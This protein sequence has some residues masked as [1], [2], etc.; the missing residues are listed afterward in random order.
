MGGMDTSLTWLGRL[1]GAPQDCDW[2]R[3]SE[4]Y[5]PLI[6][7]WAAR[8]GVCSSDCDDLVQEVLIV[9]ARKVREF[10]HQHSGAFRGW[11]RVIL[12]NQLKKYFRQ[13]RHA[14]CRISLDDFG[15]LSCEDS[16]LYDREHD[17]FVAAQAMTLIRHEFEPQTWAAFQLLVVE[18]QSPIDVAHQLNMSR[19]AVVKA[20]CRV[21]KRLREAL[22]CLE[23]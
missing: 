22:S 20:R 11:L 23:D 7:G 8:A 14:H 10:E 4:I 5:H 1:I 17:V 2:Q 6:S 12:A 21:L 15:D 13:N 16:L 19:N 9:V 18:D 3:L